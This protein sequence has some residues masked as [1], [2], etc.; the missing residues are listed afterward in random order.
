MGI[1]SRHPYEVDCAATQDDAAQLLRFR[2]YDLAV[3][4]IDQLSEAETG[5]ALA[6]ATATLF[7]TSNDAL[8]SCILETDNG[9]SSYWIEPFELDRLELLLQRLASRQAER[10]RHLITHGLL[11]LDVDSLT[12]EKAGMS[13]D[14]TSCEYALLRAFVEQPHRV[15]RHH[16]IEGLADRQIQAEALLADLRAKVGADEILTVR[17]V[18][19][20]LKGIRNGA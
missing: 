3:V 10:G 11:T 18:G 13:L 8:A 15:F 16:E 12:A 9:R 6:S 2:T 4:D 7:L 17:G 20:R 14:L 5:R 1:L 19:F